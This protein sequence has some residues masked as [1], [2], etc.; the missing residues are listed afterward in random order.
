VPGAIQHGR[1]LARHA[2][3]AC[4]ILV[5]FALAG[6]RYDDFWHD[7]FFSFLQKSGTEK[8]LLALSH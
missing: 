7:A 2:Y 6:R 8:Q 5:E 3:A 1:N 4:G